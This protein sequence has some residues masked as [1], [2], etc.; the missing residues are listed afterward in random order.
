M[1]M[2]VPELVVGYFLGM[3]ST[4]VFIIVVAAI[5]MRKNKKENIYA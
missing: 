5:Y 1:I 2:F 4:I 3:F